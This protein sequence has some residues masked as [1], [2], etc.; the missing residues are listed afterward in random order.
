MPTAATSNAGYAV[1]SSQDQTAL[2]LL[3]Q[4]VGS[5]NWAQWQ[6]LR[7]DFYD[8]VWYPYA[9]SGAAVILTP[10]NFF[11]VALGGVDPNAPA[12]T[13]K[14]TEDT[15]MVQA[16]QF[17]Q[18]YM[19]VQQIRTHLHLKPKI[20]QN[21]TVGTTTTYTYDQE[22]VSAALRAIMGTGLLTINIGQKLYFDIHQP[23]RTAPP[24]FGLGQVIVP[25]DYATANAASRASNVFISQSNSLDDVY[26]LTPP[27]LIEPAQTFQATL[28]YPDGTVNPFYH[29]LDAAAQN[30]YVQAGLIF[31]GYLARAM[32]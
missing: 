28:A 29:A 26:N 24:G 5:A 12:G 15:N 3:V 10:L 31:D 20:R 8:Y 13:V 32:Q 4:Q 2:G 1:G 16:S 7:Y 22:V 23:F 27:Q 6:I 30:A 9:P 21:T 11:A 17:G 19:V 18:N 14:T 25:Y